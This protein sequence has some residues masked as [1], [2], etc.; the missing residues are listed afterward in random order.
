M[1]AMY[2]FCKHLECRCAFYQLFVGL[3]LT[4]IVVFFLDAASGLRAPLHPGLRFVSFQR[5]FCAFRHGQQATFDDFDGQGVFASEEAR[6]DAFGDI[7]LMFLAKFFK[8]FEWHAS[9]DAH[10]TFH[11]IRVQR[12]NPRLQE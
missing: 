7:M 1:A 5:F 8:A 6:K 12:C 9:M 3:H 4:F 10:H 2:L 11:R